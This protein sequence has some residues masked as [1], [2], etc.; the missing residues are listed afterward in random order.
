MTKI[1]I[2]CTVIAVVSISVMAY[3]KPGQIKN[4]IVT[5]KMMTTDDAAS[6]REI[7][8][9]LEKYYEIARLNDSESLKNFSR[10]ISAP[11]YRYSSEL[12]VMDKEA[13]LKL[14]DSVKARFINAEFDD[15]TIQ[16]HGDT[17]VAKYRDFSKIRIGRETMQTP[18]RFTNVWQRR[19][20][21]WL[22]VAEHSSLIAPPELKP[23]NLLKDKIAKK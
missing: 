23:Q 8:G 14:F 5:E 13:A 3:I 22:I 19:D 6:E 4:V 2:L 11:E 20:G 16:I 1:L 15:L 9:I 12:G 17:A 7:R 18:M 21:R 10:S